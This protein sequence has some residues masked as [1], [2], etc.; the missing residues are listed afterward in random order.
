MKA[1]L[2]IIPLVF[3]ALITPVY[4]KDLMHTITLINENKNDS[5]NINYKLVFKQGDKYIYSEKKSISLNENEAVNIKFSPRDYK[6][7]GIIIY[8]INKHSVQDN[9]IHIGIPKGCSL[10][11]SEKN[12]TGTI[13]I[14]Y[15]DY[16][17]NTEISCLA[18]GGVLNAIS[19]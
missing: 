3:S 12:P 5:I 15:K 14:N 4:A 6:K 13:S 16:E 1:K 2:L 7:S 18:K 9:S 19:D 17:H 10:L 11:T 8:S